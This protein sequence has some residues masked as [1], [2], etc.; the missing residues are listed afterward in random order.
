VSRARRR[1]RDE[2]S[3]FPEVELAEL[4]LAPGAEVRFR[5]RTDERWKTGRVAR[6]ER[7]GSVGLLDAK[8]SARALPI[9]CIEVRTR[10][11]RGGWT[12]EALAVRAARTEQQS[13]W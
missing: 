7:D 4:G 8:G 1:G 3:P 9:D 10:G 13:L 2:P 11:T 12:W 5:R 6:R